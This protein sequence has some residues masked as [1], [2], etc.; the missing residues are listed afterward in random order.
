ML[1]KYLILDIAA[2]TEGGWEPESAGAGEDDA[3]TPEDHVGTNRRQDGA[4][5]G[6][7]LDGGLLAG[8]TTARDIVGGRR[9]TELE[10]E[11]RRMAESESVV[12]IQRERE[13]EEQC[14]ESLHDESP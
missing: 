3:A 5:I 7:S 4:A 2:G 12:A 1:W 11:E 9:E 10:T 8:A 6:R 14:E 13:S